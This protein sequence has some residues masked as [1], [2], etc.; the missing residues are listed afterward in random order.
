[1]RKSAMATLLLIAA[2]AII[3]P[4]GVNA[5]SYRRVVFGQ[6]AV[7]V[8]PD[9]MVFGRLADCYDI[10]LFDFCTNERIG[11]VTDCLSDIVEVPDCTGGMNLTTTTTF[12][13]DGAGTLV[14]RS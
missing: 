11:T 8:Q 10:P 1:M 6:G 13:I 4:L 3:L 12:A 14:V 5:G 7:P 2:L 9:Q